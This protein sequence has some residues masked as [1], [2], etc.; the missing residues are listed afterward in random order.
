[1][2]LSTVEEEEAA[3]AVRLQK[4]RAE[5]L[6]DAPVGASSFAHLLGKRKD[7]NEDGA[8]RKGQQKTK[9]AK[10]GRQEKKKVVSQHEGEKEGWVRLRL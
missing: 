9:M 1:M 6:K 7:Q 8:S 4:K 3:E 5:K 10:G 2:D